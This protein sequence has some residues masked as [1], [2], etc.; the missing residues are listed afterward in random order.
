[1][2][3]CLVAPRC[4]SE[5]I[6]AGEKFQVWAGRYRLHHVYEG[7][8]FGGV[9]SAFPFPPRRVYAAGR[10]ARSSPSEQAVL[11][12]ERVCPAESDAVPRLAPCQKRG[13][14]ESP[15]AGDVIRLLDVFV[16]C[17]QIQ[18]RPIVRVFFHGQCRDGF[19]AHCRICQRAAFAVA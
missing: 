2:A 1:M 14:L 9:S 8:R 12:R 15:S 6:A 16:D 19:E 7:F 5:P 17:P 18:V 13:R 3:Q 4:P 11:R 10:R